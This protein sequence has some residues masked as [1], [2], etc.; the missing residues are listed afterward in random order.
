MTPGPGPGLSNNSRSRS[1]LQEHT[2]VSASANQRPVLGAGDQWEASSTRWWR[3]CL[4][5]WRWWAG[6]RFRST[7]HRGTALMYQWSLNNQSRSL[8]STVNVVCWV[9]R[10]NGYWIGHFNVMNDRIVR[11]TSAKSVT[12]SHESRLSVPWLSWSEWR[13]SKASTLWMFYQFFCGFDV[14]RFC[15]VLWWSKRCLDVDHCIIPS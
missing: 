4:W 9:Q 3:M 1:R 13:V 12:K 2:G 8:R 10:F 15:G 14:R 6:R 5:W 11:M 7:D